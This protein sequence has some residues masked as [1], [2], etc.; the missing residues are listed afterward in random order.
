MGSSPLCL[1]NSLECSSPFSFYRLGLCVHF[2][3]S[4]LSSLG[5]SGKSL[6]PTSCFTI[7]AQGLQEYV[8][9][10]SVMKLPGTGSP[11]TSDKCLTDWAIFPT[12]NC[13]LH[14]L[15][16]TFTNIKAE[17]Y[18]TVPHS[19][20]CILESWFV[21]HLAS[22]LP[23]SS[24]LRVKPRALRICFLLLFWVTVQVAQAALKVAL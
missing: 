23:C 10:L 7:G 18:S 24:L 6:I 9:L 2:L 3:D 22:L 21:F 15:I 13:L 17:S 12:L 5:A 8:A 4:R 14:T 19:S 20:Y 16:T 11:P 1:E